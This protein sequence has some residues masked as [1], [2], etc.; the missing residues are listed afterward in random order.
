MKKLD[1]FE[2]SCKIILAVV[3]L[4]CVFILGKLD[5]YKNIIE[6]RVD[7]SENITEKI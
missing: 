2:I 3:L 5:A 4:E 7:M 6:D 1:W